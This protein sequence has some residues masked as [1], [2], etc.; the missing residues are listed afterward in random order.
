MNQAD[1]SRILNEDQVGISKF[2]AAVCNFVEPHMTEECDQVTIDCV[3]FELC[4]AIDGFVHGR[5]ERL[6]A[7]MAPEDEPAG[8]RTPM[9]KYFT[10]EPS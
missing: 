8:E 2:K 6:V 9:Q 3:M 5:T 10:G 7:L 4:T 1:I